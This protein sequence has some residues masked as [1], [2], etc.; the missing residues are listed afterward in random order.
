MRRLAVVFVAAALAGCA[1]TPAAKA[2]AREYYGTLE[3]FASEA[4]YFLL[5]DRFVD[6][7]PSNNHVDQGGPDPATRTFDRLVQVDGYA[8]ANIGYLGGDFKGVLDNAQ[9]IADMGFT[10]IWT[11]PIVDNPDEAF[12]GSHVPGRGPVFYDINANSN[13]R[14]PVGLAMGF[15]PFERVAQWL[16]GQLA[17]LAE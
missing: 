17:A 10:A 4:V 2:P 14:R 13:L 9:Y 16:K 12:T 1:G 11:T 15:D 6:G 3:P 5:T 8:P 7:D